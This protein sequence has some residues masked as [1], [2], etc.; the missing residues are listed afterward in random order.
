MNK[1]SNTNVLRKWFD[2]NGDSTHRLNYPLNEKSIVL[3][4]GGYKGEWSDKIYNRFKCT[5]HVFEPVN[6]FYNNIMRHFG[7]NPKVIPHKFGLSNKD[8]ISEI[9]ID[10]DSSS[11]FRGS[12]SETIQLRN[13]PDFMSTHNIEFVDLI[14]I[15]IEGG[16]YDLLDDVI[17]KDMQG[18]FGNIQ[19][20]F[21][22][23]VGDCDNRRNRIHTE[24][25]KTHELTYNYEFVWENWEL[26]THR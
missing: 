13:L 21:H 17:A 26:K 3:D 14:K 12:K 2:D 10:N 18:K 16:E 7:N 15:N 11:M 19:V 8:G 1:I 25:K 22:N 23:F 9:F 6:E 4:I 5:V 20:Q 24:L